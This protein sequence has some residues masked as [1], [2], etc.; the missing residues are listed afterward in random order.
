MKY[1]KILA[2]FDKSD[3]ATDAV[4]AAVDLALDDPACTVSV[5]AVMPSMTDSM[6]FSGLDGDIL[7]ATNMSFDGELL[8][9]MQDNAMTH[10]MSDMQA[11]LADIV[12][13]LGDRCTMSISFSSS[14]AT[15]ILGFSKKNDCDLIVMGSRGLGALRGLLGSVSFAVLRSAPI[16][17]LIVK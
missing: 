12:A 15:G 2:A 6:A 8:G 14:P 1:R 10:E 5:L 17:V 3:Q 9:Q 7:G 11:A 16:P 4:K 13:P